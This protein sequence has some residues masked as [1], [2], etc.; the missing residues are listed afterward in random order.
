LSSF[1][2]PLPAAR[3]QLSSF[4]PLSNVC[5]AGLASLVGFSCLQSAI[6]NLKSEIHPL[7]A[8]PELVEGLRS[9]L[10]LRALR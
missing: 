9:R 8:C 4:L 5:S 7:P 10:T 1:L 6:Y 3:C 2:F